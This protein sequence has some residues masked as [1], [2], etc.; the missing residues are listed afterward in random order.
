MGH[1][2]LDNHSLLSAAQIHQLHLL[3]GAAE[4]ACAQFLK[5]GDGIGGKEM[6][7]PGRVPCLL[8][9]SPLLP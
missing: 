8:R 5:L 1:P 3:D 6:R 7:A 2:S 9:R 4:K